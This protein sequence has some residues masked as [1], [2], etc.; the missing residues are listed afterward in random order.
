M[1]G[2]TETI[3]PRESLAQIR[4]ADFTIDDLVRISGNRDAWVRHQPTGP[5]EDSKL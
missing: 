1:I 3:T 2:P 4:V 5:D